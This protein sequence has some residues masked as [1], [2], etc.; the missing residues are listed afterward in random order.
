MVK[1]TEPECMD[2]HMRWEIPGGKVDYGETPQEA[3]VR[4]LKEETGVTVR[5]KR[6]LPKVF[7]SYWDY[8]WGVQHTLLFCYECRL[9][10]QTKRIKD[11]HVEEVEWVVLSEVK[12]LDRLP[13]VDFFISA[14][15]A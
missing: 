4:E 3:V 7:T 15:G 5:I 1:R 6:L 11:H 8:S 2:A 10:S 9:V 13:G 14:L 12:K